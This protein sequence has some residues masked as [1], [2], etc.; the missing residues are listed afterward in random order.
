[1]AMDRRPVGSQR[2][3]RPRRPEPGRRLK[4]GLRRDEGSHGRGSVPFRGFV[5]PLWPK[6][7][8]RQP[9]R[10]LP[11]IRVTTVM[12]PAARLVWSGG[13]ML[14]PPIRQSALPR[15][16]DPGDRWGKRVPTQYRCPSAALPR[17]LALWPGGRCTATARSCSRPTGAQ[18][19]RGAVKLLS[20]SRQDAALKASHGRDKR[21]RKAVPNQHGNSAP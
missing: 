3:L 1:M 15:P 21:S 11:T 9:P 16:E 6:P 2:V 5:S 20:R 17:A 18:S 7:T 13:R 10:S 12:R 19:A 8:R 4:T 14:R